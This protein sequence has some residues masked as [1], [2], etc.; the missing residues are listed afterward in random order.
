LIGLLVGSVFGVFFSGEDSGTGHSM[1][2]VVTELTTE[3]Y[4]RIED[5]K[6]QN[7]H[8]VVEVEAMSIDW[9]EVLALYAVKVNT[10]ADN[11][12]E[13]A[14][15]DDA[16][17]EKLRD[18]L[19]DTV[20]LTHSIRTESYGHTV[21]T[22]DKDGKTKDATETVTVTILVISMSKKSADEMAAQ[23][24][25][26]DTQATQMHELLSPDYASLWAALI[27]GYVPGNG[28]IGISDGNHVPKDI[29]DWPIGAGYS[30]TSG[31]G[32][33]K[34]PFTGET[35][36]HG[37]VDIAAP[38]GTP[39]LAAADGTVIVANATDS[40][41]GGWG[42]YV[43]LKHNDTYA[44]LYAHCSRIAVANGQ[45]VK[46]GQVIAYVGTTGNSTGNHLHFEVYLNGTRTNPLDYFE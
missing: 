27:G 38:E 6:S 17:I 35:R 16:K 23:Y 22:T 15:L 29:F 28:E 41:G 5:I 19:N 20:N 3:F 12:M 30:V 4:S 46:K 45:E 8:D 37:G 26:S 43:K 10:D 40:W 44:T 7:A 21:T 32:Y 42:Y 33:R 13:V 11:A 18:V 14:T 9:R 2:A 36:Y 31:F 24:C 34:D 1:P 25:F 39:I